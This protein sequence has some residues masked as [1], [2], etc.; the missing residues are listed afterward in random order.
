[1]QICKLFFDSKIK[2]LESKDNLYIRDSF[3][4]QILVYI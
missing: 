2:K 4:I 1:M 3:F